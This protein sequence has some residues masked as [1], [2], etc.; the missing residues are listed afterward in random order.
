[1]ISYEANSEPDTKW[2]DRLLKSDFGTTAQIKEVSFQYR[3]NNQTPI[4][5]KFLDS[6]GNIVGQ[7]LLADTPRFQEHP[8]R[9]K[10]FSNKLGKVSRIL[11]IA[12]VKTNLYRWSY[13]PVIFNEEFNEEIYQ[14][15]KKFLLSDKTHQILGWQNPLQTKGIFSIKNSFSIPKWG[16]FLIDLSKTNDEL[17]QNI[18]KHSGR[19][20]IQRAIKRDISIEEITEQ[21][22]HEYFSL[23]VSSK[24]KRGGLKSNFE[25]F[26]KVWK[27]LQP[28][29]RRGFL[30]RKNSVPISGLMFSALCGQIIEYGVARSFS[31]KEN[32]YYS[33]DL[34]RWKI[35]EWGS[36]NNMKWYNLAGFNPDL[37]SP[38]EQ[39]IYRYKKKWGGEMV[40]YYG[41]QLK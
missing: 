28:F 36:E 19:K 34:I 3:Q 38:K 29:G 20:N 30:A 39:G 23:L 2:N 31:D 33:Q 14:T 18:E 6:K 41:I 7:L 11:K 24:E 8:N 13:G 16:T 32:M 22:L 9:T 37:T 27:M 26:S 5:L 4:F 35:I 10:S 17:F 40:N 1:M 15:L 21:N 25:Y 12:N